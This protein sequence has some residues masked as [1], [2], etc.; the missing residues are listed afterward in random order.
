MFGLF[1]FFV[2]FFCQSLLLF[3]CPWCPF[4]WFDHGLPLLGLTIIYFFFGYTLVLYL[5]LG[6]RFIYFLSAQLT[7][8][9]YEP[10]LH[11]ALA[12]LIKL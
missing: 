2:L 9:I 6:H 11:L 1:L 12:C 8:I 4:V 10:V 5:E 3:F 7:K